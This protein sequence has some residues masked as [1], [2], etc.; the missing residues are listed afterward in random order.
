MTANTDELSA[1]RIVAAALGPLRTEV[2]FVGGMIRSLLITDPAAPMARATDDIDLVAATA[3]TTEYYLLAER[4]RAL[5]FREDRREKAPLCRWLVQGLTVDVMPD[6]ENVLGFSNRWYQ[7]AGRTAK[8]HTIGD[9]AS[10]RIRVVDA[11][12]FVATKLTSFQSRGEANFY[13]HDM[14]DIVAVVDG[15]EELLPE[16]RESPTALRNFVT[17]EIAALLKN[18]S[19]ME[20][21]PGHLPGDKASQARLALLE[22]R[23]SAMAARAK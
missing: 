9:E 11:P 18:D 23:L 2:V 8:L 5:G 3:S 6:R 20:S 7:S 17:S 19:F 1:L 14:E 21:L 4:L 15:R 22:R 13:H 10:A 12:H 16:L